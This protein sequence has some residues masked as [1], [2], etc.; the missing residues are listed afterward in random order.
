MAISVWSCGPSTLRSPLIDTGEYAS[1]E[2]CRSTFA[3]DFG[4]DESPSTVPSSACIP[5]E[6]FGFTDR[7]VKF[8]CPDCTTIF[9]TDIGMVCVAGPAVAVGGAAGPRFLD[10]AGADCDA[11]DCAAAGPVGTAPGVANTRFTFMLSSDSMMTLAYGLRATIRS[12]SR[13]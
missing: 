2:P 7:S 1:T 9:L 10:V 6:K 4:L 13:R 12:I 3:R 8:A 5:D 11:T